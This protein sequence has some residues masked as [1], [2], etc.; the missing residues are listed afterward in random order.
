VVIAQGE[1]TAPYVGMPG[2][3]VERGAADVVQPLPEIARA[4]PDR[5][6]RHVDGMSVERD[7]DFEALFDVLRL[8]RGFDGVRAVDRRGQPIDRTVACQPLREGGSVMG[9]LVLVGDVPNRE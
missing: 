9:V 8:E 2:A 7:P 3:A 6:R 5:G 1:A 4:R